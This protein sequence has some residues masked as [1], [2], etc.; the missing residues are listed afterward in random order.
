MRVNRVLDCFL[1]SD[2]LPTCHWSFGWMAQP[3]PEVVTSP[4]FDYSG[5]L[6]TSSDEFDYSGVLFFLVWLISS[7]RPR[8]FMNVPRE[9]S[10]VIPRELWTLWSVEFVFSWEVVKVYDTDQTRDTGRITGYKTTIQS[11]TRSE[12]WEYRHLT[13]KTTSFVILLLCFWSLAA[14]V[15]LAPPSWQSWVEIPLSTALTTAAC[16]IDLLLSE[17]LY[18]STMTNDCRK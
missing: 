5:V 10:K 13:V 9:P 2:L 8:T 12:T 11:Q 4:E 14:I 3:R 6:P 1:Y 17:F 7:N 15:Y 16:K 18:F